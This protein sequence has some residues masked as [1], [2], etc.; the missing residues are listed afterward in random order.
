MAQEYTIKR[1]SQNPPREWAGTHGTVYYIKVQLAEHGRFVEI[2][3]KN[4]DALKVGDKV[5]GTIEPTPKFETDRFK[6][7][8]K[9]DGGGFRGQPKD[10]A[11]IKAMWAIG[12]AVEALDEPDTALIEELAKELYAMVERVKGGENT[13][14]P[15]KPLAEQWKEIKNTPNDDAPPPDDDD[16][17]ISLA[18]IPF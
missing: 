14:Q 17:P 15:Q 18:D 1:I 16:A 11:A 12:K 7:E 9:P 6:A 10:E 3:K 8:R 4:P 5:Y 13:P 2:G